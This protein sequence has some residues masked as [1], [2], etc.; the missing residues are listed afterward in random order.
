VEVAGEF[1]SGSSLMPQKRNPD[2]AELVR[3]KTGRVYGHLVALLSTLKALPLSYNRD[4]QED[5]EGLFDT[6]DTLHLCLGVMAGMVG[7][8]KVNRERM[9][10]A[11]AEGYILATDVADYLVR[12]GVP[13]R[14]AHGIVARLVAYAQEKG[15]A[16]SQLTLEEYK[17]ASPLFEKD[18]YALSVA[19]ALT[20]RDRKGGTAPSQVSQALQ[21]ARQ[22]LSAD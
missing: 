1:A 20:A 21:L 15:K 2:A 19:T 7:S 18:V 12:K 13:F 6:V 3:G 17:K 4:L 11:V 16:F 8:L 14:E 22:R 9:A 5:K 10:K